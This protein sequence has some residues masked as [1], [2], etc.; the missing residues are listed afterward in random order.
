M[1]G[2]AEKRRLRGIRHNFKFNYDKK[3]Y[4]DAGYAPEKKRAE[5]T[6]SDGTR[7]AR[8][9]LLSR[10]GRGTRRQ[11]AASRRG[12]GA[13]CRTRATARAYGSKTGK[14]TRHAGKTRSSAGR[15]VLRYRTRLS[16]NA[17]VSAVSEKRRCPTRGDGRATGSI[18]TLTQTDTERS[19]PALCVVAD[20]GQQQPVIP[21]TN[22][23]KPLSAVPSARKRNLKV[24][25]IRLNM[26]VSTAFDLH[27]EMVFLLFNVL[28]VEIRYSVF[29]A[30][31]RLPKTRI[32]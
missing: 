26:V 17:D 23:K 1:L 3:T 27:V 16:E 30:G 12:R 10:G 4:A 31:F 18:G 28:L 2:L 11:A 25:F 6:K 9:G 5:Q 29:F 8:S 14:P 22:S 19:R 24:H 32:S 7:G 13:V 15:A 20:R 21:K